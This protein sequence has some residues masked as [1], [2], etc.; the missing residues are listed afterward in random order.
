MIE[1]K[2]VEKSFN[3]RTVLKGISFRVR[4]GEIFGYLG[5]NGAGKTTTVRILTGLIK[6]DSG[7]VFI[8]GY[9]VTKDPE[10]A[11]EKVGI[12][13]EVSNVYP[14]LTAWQNLM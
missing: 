2:N 5:P 4:K 12:L 8:R 11:R 14:D 7:N 6:P 13:P 10:K 3:G 9:D 1:V